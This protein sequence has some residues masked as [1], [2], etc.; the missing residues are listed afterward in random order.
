MQRNYSAREARKKKEEEKE[1][2]R[3][4]KNAQNTQSATNLSA[5][6]SRPAQSSVAQQSGGVAQALASSDVQATVSQLSTTHAIA[7]TP[8]A[9]ATASLPDAVISGVGR[10]TRFW[11]FIGCVPAQYTNGHN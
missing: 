11:L 9:T 1:K 7:P 10:W 5:G 4:A 6:N 2:L 8:A 3:N